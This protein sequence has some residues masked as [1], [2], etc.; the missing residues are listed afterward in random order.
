MTIVLFFE[1][2][3]KLI[4]LQHPLTVLSL[5]KATDNFKS[6]QLVSV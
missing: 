6:M 5:G 3:G 4:P 2:N 1:A